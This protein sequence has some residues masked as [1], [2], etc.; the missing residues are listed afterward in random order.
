VPEAS[1]LAPV[2]FTSPLAN[3]FPNEILKFDGLS[4]LV[5][6]VARIRALTPSPRRRLLISA[7]VGSGDSDSACSLSTASLTFCNKLLCPLLDLRCQV[8]LINK[9][10]PMK[11]R[12]ETGDSEM[13]VPYLLECDPSR[14]GPYNGNKVDSGRRHPELFQE[15]SSPENVRWWWL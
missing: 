2:N 9:L 10:K 8:R 12:R 11:I 5:V 13:N 15:V 6:F 1:W 4:H 14:D 3:L 7:H